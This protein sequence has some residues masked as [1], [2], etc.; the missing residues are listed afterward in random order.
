MPTSRQ[1]PEAPPPP[2][3]HPLVVT[4]WPMS[5]SHKGFAAVPIPCPPGVF[6]A[7]PRFCRRCTTCVVVLEPSTRL[8][9]FFLGPFLG[10]FEENPDYSSPMHCVTMKCL[11][12]FTAEDGHHYLFMCVVETSCHVSKL[13]KI[14]AMLGAKWLLPKADFLPNT[15]LYD[16]FAD[17]FREHGL[18]V[19]N[20][21]QTQL[22]VS[23]FVFLTPL[24]GTD[25]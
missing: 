18:D 23:Y 24:V 4:D 3:G 13:C 11:T 14:A 9:S 2:G 8:Q 17:L 16:Y 20:E 6:G 19:L 21:N 7:A 1:P 22:L 5:H 15:Y 10:L 12:Y 25:A